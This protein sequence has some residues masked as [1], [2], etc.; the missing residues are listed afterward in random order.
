MIFLGDVASPYNELPKVNYSFGK[1]PVV[2]NLEG[3]I[4]ESADVASELL[5]EPVLFNHCS[6]LDYMSIENVVAVNLANNHINDIPKGFNKTIELLEGRNVGWFGLRHHDAISLSKHSFEGITYI[7]IGFGWDVI[8]CDYNRGGEYGV[9][10]LSKSILLREIEKLKITNPNA[11]II[12]NFHWN[13][14]M[15]LYPQPGHRSLAQDAIDTG[16]D[17][18]IGHHPHVVSGIE[19]YNG[20]PIVYSLGNWWLPQGVFFNGQLKYNDMTYRQLAFRFDAAGEHELYWFNYNPS[21]KDVNFDFKESLFDSEL[22]KK[23]T[24][25]DGMSKEAYQGWF[26]KNRLKKSFLPIFKNEEHNFRNKIKSQFVKYRHPL[27][28][29]IRRFV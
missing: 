24:P 26:K 3:P 6:I 14:E 10:P 13:Y 5:M 8:Q 25:F 2:L 15:E 27:I 1:K 9:A 23:L 18:V 12:V 22:V 20:K 16:A 19:I 29:L 21:R 28:L 11:K 17:A 4:I 7:L